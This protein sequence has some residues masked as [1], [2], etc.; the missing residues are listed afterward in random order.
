MISELS[1]YAGDRLFIV[2]GPE[3]EDRLQFQRLCESE[4][5]RSIEA[6]QAGRVH[7]LTTDWLYGDPISL[8]GQLAELPAVMQQ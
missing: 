4:L 5:W 6:V 1:H 7:L 3:E 8:E 2:V